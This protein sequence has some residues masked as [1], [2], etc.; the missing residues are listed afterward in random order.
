MRR[1]HKE[2]RGGLDNRSA[3]RNAPDLYPFSPQV[4]LALLLVR[5]ALEGERNYRDETRA[6]ITKER[7]KGKDTLGH[8]YAFPS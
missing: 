6:G 4:A 1:Q 3:I 5:F 8:P 7:K 2:L